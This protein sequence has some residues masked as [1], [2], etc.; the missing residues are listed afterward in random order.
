MA[1][2]QAQTH[3]FLYRRER[4]LLSSTAAL[5]WP[6]LLLLLM[7]L[8]GV[9][10]SV[11]HLSLLSLSLSFQTFPV[12]HLPRWL[13]PKIDDDDVCKSECVALPTV[14]NCDWLRVR[15]R[16]CVCL[17]ASSG[18]SVLAHTHTSTTSAVLAFISH[19][20]SSSY[21]CLYLW[22]WV[23]V[24]KYAFFEN[25]SV[26]RGVENAEFRVLLAAAASH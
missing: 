18:H 24:C 3:T 25:K 22:V 26:Q 11:W 15:D 6:A 1:N 16:V 2:E 7:L 19:G 21:L 23:C 12:C 13:W 5:S 20:L 4:G 10:L 9:R 17:F 14:S 8:L